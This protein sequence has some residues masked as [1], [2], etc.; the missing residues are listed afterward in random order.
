MAH[1]ADWAICLARTDPDAES[2]AGIT[3]FLVDMTSEGIDVRPL[4]EITGEAMF[5]EV[6]L[7]GVFVPDECVVGEVDG[8]WRLART[9]LANERVAMAG[10]RLG[11]SVERADRRCSETHPESRVEVGRAVA[12][13]TVVKL[14]GTRATLR[15]IAGQGPG[16][17]SSVAK[18]VGVRSRQDAAELV[19][20]LLGDRLFTDDDLARDAWH[21]L[22]HDAL[23]L[24]RRRHHAGAAQRGRRAHPRATPRLT[25]AAARA[26][27]ARGGAAASARRP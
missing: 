24:D 9:T 3:Y 22:L 25:P 17:E 8:G 27:T 14:L 23:P 16:P 19:V 13:A 4:R 10:S 6:F 15:S 20:R 7:D 11:V 12:L 5:N 18:L 21:E 1:Q 2:H 26:A